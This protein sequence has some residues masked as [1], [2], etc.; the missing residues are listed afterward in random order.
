MPRLCPTCGSAAARPLV[1][2]GSARLA[3]CRTCG[4]VFAAELPS[5][6]ELAEHY[7]DYPAAGSLPELTARRYREVLALF[8]PCRQTG[9][10]LDVGCGDGHFLAVARELGWE[11]Y[12]SEYGAAPRKRAQELGLDVREAPFPAAADEWESFDVVTAFEVIEHVVAPREELG[13][14]TRVLRPGGCVYLTTP[15]FVSLSRRLAGPRWRAIGYPEHL[16]MFTP[17]TL[18]RLL[19]DARLIRLS[20]K[21]TGISPSDIWAG[22]RPVSPQISAGETGPR[23]DER[24]RAGVASSPILDR[25]VRVANV[26]LATLG[27][28]DTIK[29]LYRR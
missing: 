16:N 27:V 29:A 5:P 11:V 21:T 10:L 26:T 17:K 13:H 15:N 23:V 20:L 6:A 18:H 24:V 22:V 3:R 2:Y 28:G 19:A 8:E 7:R 9:R 25:A 14:I 12:G 4:L 1:R